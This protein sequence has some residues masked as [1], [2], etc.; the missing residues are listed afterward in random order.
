[1]LIFNQ[2]MQLSALSYKFHGLMYASTH[3]SQHGFVAMT[4]YFEKCNIFSRFCTL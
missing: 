1:V 3:S 4:A 2:I